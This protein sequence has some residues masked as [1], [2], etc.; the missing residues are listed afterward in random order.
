M[1]LALQPRCI[2]GSFVC[3]AVSLPCISSTKISMFASMEEYIYA[4]SSNNIL[5]QIDLVDLTSCEFS[6]PF[7]PKQLEVG[8]GKIFLVSTEGDLCSLNARNG[9]ITNEPVNQVASF[10]LGADFSLFVTFDRKLHVLDMFH[11]R[12]TQI[13]DIDGVT[14]VSVFGNNVVCATDSHVNLFELFNTDAST[15]KMLLSCPIADFSGPISDVFA[16]STGFYV[17]SNAVFFAKLP[18]APSDFVCDTIKFNQ[19]LLFDCNNKAQLVTQNLYS[20]QCFAVGEASTTASKFHKPIENQKSLN[21]PNEFFQDQTPATVHDLAANESVVDEVESNKHVETQPTPDDSAANESVVDEVESNQHVETQPTPDD[22]AA[23]ESVVDEVESNQHVETQPTPDDSA[24]NESVV[25]EVESNQHVETQPTPDD[26]ATNEAVV[27]EVESNQHVETQPTLDDSAANESVVDEV[28]SNQ[29]VETQPTLDDSATNESVVDEVESNQ[30]VETQPTPDDSATNESVVDEV[31]SNQHVETQ[32]TLD[33]SATNESVVDEVESNQHVETQ[34]T[35]DDS[36]T[37]ESVVDEVESNQHVETQPTL[38]DS[39][40]NESVVDEVESNQ[41]VET[42]PTLDDPAANES[43]VDEVESNQ[44]VETQPT[45][46]DPAANESVVDEVESNQHVET[47]PRGHGLTSNET[48][49]YKTDASEEVQTQAIVVGAGIKNNSSTNT[50][51]SCSNCAKSPY[52]SSDSSKESDLEDDLDL[53]NND[54]LCFDNMSVENSQFCSEVHENHGKH[55]SYQN[56]LC[57]GDLFFHVLDH[58]C[59]MQ[60]RHHRKRIPLKCNVEK[61]FLTEKGPII[62]TDSKHYYW[63]F[64]YADDIKSVELEHY[65]GLDNLDIITF[66]HFPLSSDGT[67]YVPKR[68]EDGYFEE[69]AFVPSEVLVNIRQISACDELA[70][71]VTY[72][73]YV[74]IWNREVGEIFKHKQLQHVSQISVSSSQGLVVLNDGTLLGWSSHQEC[75]F[76]PSGVEEIPIEIPVVIDVPP[77]EY[78]EV[79]QDHAI[80]LTKEGTV[81]TFGSNKHGKCGVNSDDDFVTP[82][83]LPFRNIDHVAIGEDNSYFIKDDEIYACGERDGLLRKSKDSCASFKPAFSV[84]TGPELKVSQ[85]LKQPWDKE[86]NARLV[87]E[88]NIGIN[89]I[90]FDNWGN[91]LYVNAEG[92][93]LAKGDNNNNVLGICKTSESSFT[94]VVNGNNVT[95]VFMVSGASFFK[96]QSGQILACGNGEKL[97]IPSTKDENGNFVS[98]IKVAVPFE[99]VAGAKFFS[100]DSGNVSVLF[101][102]GKCGIIKSGLGLMYPKVLAS[103]SIT[104]I[105]SNGNSDWFVKE[106]GSVYRASP[107]LRRIVGLSK[108]VSLSVSDFSGLA[109]LNDGCVVTW[110]RCT[111]NFESG[112]EEIDLNFDGL[113]TPSLYTS[114]DAN[115]FGSNYSDFFVICDLPKIKAIAAGNFYSLFVTEE[116]KVLVIGNNDQ[117]QIGLGGLKKATVFTEIPNI[118]NA[119]GVKAYKDSSVIVSNGE[120]YITGDLGKYFFGEPC[121][122]FTKIPEVTYTPALDYSKLGFVEPKDID[123]SQD[124]ARISYLNRIRTNGDLDYTIVLNENEFV[125]NHKSNHGK[126]TLK[127]PNIHRVFASENYPVFS[128]KD[129]TYFV[130]MINH[131]DSEEVYQKILGLDAF[132]VKKFVYSTQ[133]F[134]CL[135]IIGNA[136]R[137][138]EELEVQELTQLKN[139]RQISLFESSAA[140]VTGDGFAWLWDLGN[141]SVTNEQLVCHPYLHNVKQVAIG[142]LGYDHHFHLVVLNDGKLL[143]WGNAKRLGFSN[144]EWDKIPMEFPVL[145]DVPPIEYVAVSGDH[146]ICLTKEGTV[147]TF[148]SNKHGKCGVNSDNDIMTPTLLSFHGVDHVAIG[149]SNSYIIKD[150][151]IFACGKQHGIFARTLP[152]HQFKPIISLLTGSKATL[153]VRYESDWSIEENS[154]ILKNSMYNLDRI[155]QLNDR[156]VYVNN[157]GKVL[158]MG[159]QYYY[160]LGLGHREKPT[161][162]TQIPLCYSIQSVYATQ[163]FTFFKTSEGE[164]YACGTDL[165]VFKALTPGVRIEKNQKVVVNL[166]NLGSF[167]GVCNVLSDNVIFLNGSATLYK[168]D[169]QSVELLSDVVQMVVSGD[170]SVWFLSSSGHVYRYSKS[171]KRIVGLSRVVLISVSE[172]HGLALLHDGR[173]VSWGKANHNALGYSSSNVPDDVYLDDGEITVPE[174]SDSEE[175]FGFSMHETYHYKVIPHLPKIK[176]VSAGNHYSLFVTE[177]G[178]VLVIGNNDKGQI[179]LGGLKKAKVLTEVPNIRDASGVRT[180]DNSSVIVSNGELHV[181][182]DLGNYFFGEPC[183]TFT[184]IPEVTYTPAL[185]Y[186]NLGF[187]EPKDIDYSQDEVR[188]SYLNRIRLL[189]FGEFHYFD[190]KQNYCK[191]RSESIVKLAICEDFVTKYILEDYVIVCNSIGQYFVANSSDQLDFHHI[192]GL[193]NVNVKYFCCSFSDFG[194]SFSLEICEILALTIDGTVFIFKLNKKTALPTADAQLMSEISSVRQMTFQSGCCAFVT[195]DGS[196]YYWNRSDPQHTIVRHPTLHNVKHVAIGS[197]SYFLNPTLVVLNDGTLLGWGTLGFD[198][199]IPIETPVIIDVPPMEYV[200]VSEDHAVCLT[201]EGT[202]YTFGRN[203]YGKCGVNSGEEFIMPTLLPFEGVDHVAVGSQCSFFIKDDIIYRCGYQPVSISENSNEFVPI[204]SFANGHFLKDLGRAIEQ[205]EKSTCS[206]EMHDNDIELNDESR[207]HKFESDTE[208]TELGEPQ[209]TLDDSAANESVVDE[210]ESNQHVETQPTLDDSAVN[211]S[212]VDEV[213]SNQHVETQPTLDDS[214][215]NEAVVDEVK[216]NQHVETQPTLDDSAVN[217][218]VVDEVESN[219]HVETQPTLDDSAVN[220]SVV[221]EVESNQHVETQPTLDDSATNEAVVD[222]VESN[223]HVETQPTLDDSATNEA[224]VDEVESNQHVETQPTLDDSAVNES[225]VDEVESNQHVET[226]PTLDDSAVNDVVDEA[227]SPEHV[228]TQPTFDDSAVN[229]VVDEAKSNEQIENK[230]RVQDL[231]ILSSVTN[232]ICESGDC[233]NP[234]L[235]PKNSAIK[236]ELDQ[237]SPKPENIEFFGHLRKR[238]KIFKTWRQRWFVLKNSTLS[239]FGSL[240][241]KTPKNV[242]FLSHNS[243]V[244]HISTDLYNSFKATKPQS[245]YFVVSSTPDSRLFVLEAESETD[246]NIWIRK[247]R[248]AIPS[249]YS[250]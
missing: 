180:F 243:S 178:K 241:D 85:L 26:S 145:I 200:A 223:Q 142:N 50:S 125:F 66:T 184:K 126:M 238:G 162:F 103:S 194:N 155:A 64:K 147:Y 249:D 150:D 246:C 48:K 227:E 190:C 235:G 205:G 119:S 92:K 57:K 233:L 185:D 131:Q 173:V 133:L 240:D 168:D 37:N 67:V 206:P 130:V 220:E 10:A 177:E 186:S 84:S 27:D 80:C 237:Q 149:K 72:D 108:V 152:L 140:F 113:S 197:L 38:D 129:L 75:G 219:Q 143:G 161:A 98:E 229:D 250:S 41:N 102:D 207:I 134:L 226:Q 110:G 239:Y 46:D 123:Y 100:G 96:T 118:R 217:E 45:L 33:D 105:T 88:A 151:I 86:V 163:H 90:A 189:G 144:D 139:V 167:H 136:Y 146:A 104:M 73:G 116:G 59:F 18:E 195:F 214:A 83:L 188:I 212:V 193:D 242:I 166:G 187:V 101:Q 199:T 158:G 169:S 32:P 209:P 201:K 111:F 53:N 21:P 211:E 230:P 49:V 69:N 121:T 225:V 6:L 99:D 78:V 54:V 213:E 156:L 35:L 170:K 210:V 24:A 97:A 181:A 87:R 52:E 157:E 208:S 12:S 25:D 13:N 62:K 82:T 39:A 43:V 159:S 196:L 91:L 74:W 174:Y 122:T 14:H 36:A 138:S 29:H 16:T 171:L 124:E 236:K 89:R 221:D 56:K 203:M 248:Q 31:E 172:T 40:A 215:T 244:H 55:L 28:E 222:E 34:P 224:V 234:L 183:T 63:N 117:G 182:G 2:E 8:Y 76:M 65:Q 218:S 44:N 95:D 247:I 93:L 7:K 68:D 15:V 9:K 106:D 191:R 164:V 19:I 165:N 135:D 77:M 204:A 132:E 70:A 112:A 47:Q 128:T 179:G 81:Y 114:E 61:F 231:S 141:Y 202:V 42:Q 58:A 228:E 198:K 1:Y 79:S 51:F 11:R 30:H 4:I 23:N 107:D 154:L 216:S 160:Q 148:G 22:S 175:E 3:H 20:Q 176:A 60:F 137:I 127:F 232:V 153:L 17:V 245:H 120:L 94:Q 192:T 115:G 109:L 71:F 5:H